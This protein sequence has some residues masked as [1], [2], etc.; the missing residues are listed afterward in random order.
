MNPGAHVYVSTKYLAVRVA[1]NGV[2][3]DWRP[4]KKLAL[5]HLFDVAGASSTELVPKKDIRPK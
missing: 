1:S 5:V 3:E 2:V 4:G